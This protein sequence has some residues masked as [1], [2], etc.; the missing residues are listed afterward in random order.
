MGETAVEAR[1]GRVQKHVPGVAIPPGVFSSCHVG[2]W[3]DAP[4][5]GATDLEATQRPHARALTAT[6][7]GTGTAVLYSL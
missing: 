4:T 5:G 1:T 7:T 2:G 6:A 3:P